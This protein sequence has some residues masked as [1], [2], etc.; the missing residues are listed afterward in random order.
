M[1][2]NKLVIPRKQ[3]L[4]GLS[5]LHRR[6]AETH[7]SGAFLLGT[8][9]GATGRVTKWVFYDDLD[10]SAYSSGV[11]VLYADAFDQLWNIC[12]SAGLEVL[13]DIH[14]HG[15][16]PQQSVSDRENPMIACA[17]HL[18]LI[19][20]NFARGPHWRHRMGLFCYEGEHR[21]ANLS[22]LQARNC[23]KTGTLR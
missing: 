6:G 14:T 3:W 21:W 10:P 23:I 7:E 11:C 20:P 18:A 12:R 4:D 16:S 22:G 8:C 13:A 1:D 15:G 19:I 9:A 17:G 2:K 5:D